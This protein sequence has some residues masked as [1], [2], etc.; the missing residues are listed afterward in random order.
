LLKHSQRLGLMM[1]H[2]II[3]LRLSAL[4]PLAVVPV[5]APITPILLPSTEE[6]GMIAAAISVRTQTRL[7]GKVGF[8]ASNSYCPNRLGG[9]YN[10]PPSTIHPYT[11]CLALVRSVGFP[12]RTNSAICH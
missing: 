2:S 1:R 5:S 9:C 6:I 10:Y 11:K 12:D 7:F 8:V 3:E 4:V